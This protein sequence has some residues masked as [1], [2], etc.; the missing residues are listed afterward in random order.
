M[1]LEVY[2]FEDMMNMW[3]RRVGGKESE[4]VFEGEWYCDNDCPIREIKIKFKYFEE[5]KKV[6]EYFCP[7]CKK[8]IKF[9]NFF[10]HES[11]VFKGGKND[12]GKK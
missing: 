11:L 8:K 2:S 4:D 9:H 10:H 3:F 7:Q 12:L 6:S 1:S 5:D